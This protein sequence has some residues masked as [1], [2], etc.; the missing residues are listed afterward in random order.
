MKL[1]ELLLYPILSLILVLFIYYL[2]IKDNSQPA[3]QQKAIIRVQPLQVTEQKTTWKTASSSLP[4]ENKQKQ[5]QTSLLYISMF[6]KKPFTKEQFTFIPSERIY[7]V[8]ELENLPARKHWLSATW[9]TP[10]GKTASISNHELVLQEFTPWHRTFFW[11]ELMKNGAF[12]EMFTGREYKADA[13]GKWEVVVTLNGTA[14]G[15]Q[16]FEIRDL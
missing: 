9:K 6:N 15:K 13:Y 8:I 10:N 12:T 7:L 1:S 16:H 3:L 2:A 14:I 5:K 11:M 4:A